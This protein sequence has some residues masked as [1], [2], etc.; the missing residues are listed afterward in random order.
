MITAGLKVYA[1]FGFTADV[2]SKRAINSNDLKQLGVKDVNTR[3]YSIPLRIG[4]PFM[5]NVVN[6]N[7]TYPCACF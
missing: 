4:Y 6:E 7:N 1:A 3:F 2:S 5:F